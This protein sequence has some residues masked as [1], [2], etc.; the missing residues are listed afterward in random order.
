MV[1]KVMATGT[2]LTPPSS[3]PGSEKAD[4]VTYLRNHAS[5]IES[6]SNIAIIGGGA[7]GVQMA[8][9]IKEIYPNKSVTLIHSRDRLMNKFHPHMDEIIKERCAELG[10]KLKLGSRV[11]LPAKGFPTDG[12]T[13]EVQLQ[14]GSSVATDFAV[15]RT[16]LLILP[17]GPPD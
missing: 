1:C 14:D 6:S 5:K 17:S 3:L 4:G 10:V 2:K 13:F 16:L 7:V 15:R 11:K 12:S 9:D 8:T